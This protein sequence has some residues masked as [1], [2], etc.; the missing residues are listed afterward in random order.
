MIYFSLYFEI[1]IVVL[2]WRRYGR[3]VRRNIIREE[4]IVLV[5]VRFGG[6]LDE[7]VG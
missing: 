3:G 2:S 4:F 1:S 6:G 7:V 5:W